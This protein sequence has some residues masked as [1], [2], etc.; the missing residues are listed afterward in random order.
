[1][2]VCACEYILSFVGPS[3]FFSL[4]S[5]RRHGMAWLPHGCSSM[6]RVQNGVVENPS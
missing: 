6:L 3:V 1:M 2:R 4:P 5:A